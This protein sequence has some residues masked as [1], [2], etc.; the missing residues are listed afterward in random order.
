MYV[1]VWTMQVSPI[2]ARLI[3]V[4]SIELSRQQMERDESIEI[5]TEQLDANIF[6]SLE[7]S[8]WFFVGRPS[9]ASIR[10]SAMQVK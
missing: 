7:G 8:C 3:I 1:C 10:K 5:S 4:H 6:H 9:R 2:F